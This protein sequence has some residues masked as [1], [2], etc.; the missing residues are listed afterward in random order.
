MNSL[1]EIE[2][3]MHEL[4]LNWKLRLVASSLLC[5]MGLTLLVS[6]VSGLLFD[7]TVLDQTIEAVS[8]FVI[9]IPI[10]LI[11]ADLPK[12]NEYTIASMLNESVP[13]LSQNSELVLKPQAELTEEERQLRQQ[14]E[15]VFKEKKL[16]KFLPLRPLKQALILLAFCILTTG[17]IYFFLIPQA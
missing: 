14:I 10:Y 17:V 1:N 9:M 13:E 11:I 16:Y 15:P 4:V 8:I 7:F 12:I 5:M 6:T 2:K 3:I